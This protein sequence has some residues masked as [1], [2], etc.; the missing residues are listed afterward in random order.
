MLFSQLYF[1]S[2]L[3]PVCIRAYCV[4]C[5]LMHF[6]IESRPGV[7]ENYIFNVCF[8]SNAPLEPGLLRDLVQLLAPRS[9]DEEDD[10]PG[11]G[12][13]DD[14]DAAAAS[15]GSS[16]DVVPSGAGRVALL[17]TLLSLQD[18]A[19]RDI[20]DRA[21]TDVMEG[22]VTRL[23]FLDTPVSVG[24]AVLQ[25]ELL[26]AR[27]PTLNVALQQLLGEVDLHLLQPAVPVSKAMGT[28]RARLEAIAKARRLLAL[29][30]EE[31]CTLQDAD[32]G[33]VPA[34]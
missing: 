25:E 19:S 34:G 2:F 13:S 30:A 17:R 9:E 32:A 21:L 33:V 20:I 14:S 15:R 27:A 7:M 24:Y 6:S 3:L 11:G 12:V 8:K 18:T 5:L 23:N 29:F 28:V 31:V 4:I 1:Q 22:A 16:I 10:Q 26:S